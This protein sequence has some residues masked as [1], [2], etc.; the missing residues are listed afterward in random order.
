M[1]YSLDEKLVI[2]LASSALFDLSE[3]GRV[4]EDRGLEE[5]RQYQR[6]NESVTLEPGPAF[7]L[8]R[9][10]LRLND[11]LTEAAAP[12]EVILLSRNDPDTGLPS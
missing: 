10:L 12:V 11:G 7:P 5:Y 2:T 3:S 9:R 4:Y 1:P 6:D 8:V